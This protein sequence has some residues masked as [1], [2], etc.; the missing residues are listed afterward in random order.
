MSEIR[1]WIGTNDIENIAD[2]K[3]FYRAAHSKVRRLRRDGWPESRIPH[4]VGFQYGWAMSDC[5]MAS[6]TTAESV[7]ED[8][9]VVFPAEDNDV[10]TQYVDGLLQIIVNVT[11]DKWQCRHFTSAVS[12]AKGVKA[13]DRDDTAQ[14]ASGYTAF[15]ITIN[16]KF[17][18]DLESVRASV[19]EHARGFLANLQATPVQPDLFSLEPE[20]R[21]LF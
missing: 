9:P 11:L 18:H 1:N 10:V 21:S 13:I 17:I 20:Q 15:A 16:P 14:F 3:A 7:P 4:S 8:K 2:L 5:V 19:K 6:Y 12:F